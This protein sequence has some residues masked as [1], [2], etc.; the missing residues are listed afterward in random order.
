MLRLIIWVWNV[1]Q[2]LSS[3]LGAI[4]FCSPSPS[5]IPIHCFR[6]LKSSNIL[7]KSE[8]GEC[9]IADLGLALELKP[10]D[11]PKEIAN[12]GQASLSM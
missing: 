12:Y 11:D 8:D 1:A 10:T 6:D 3:D 5:L 2:F 9:V 7:V 4:T